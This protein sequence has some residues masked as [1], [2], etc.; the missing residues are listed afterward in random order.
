MRLTAPALR[1]PLLFRYRASEILHFLCATCLFLS[2]LRCCFHCCS[3]FDAILRSDDSH[4]FGTLDI[5]IT[6]CHFEH[7]HAASATP[8][9]LSLPRATWLRHFTLQY[10][11]F[12]D[13]ST[14]AF[15][16]RAIYLI[17]LRRHLPAKCHGDMRFL[18]FDYD[19]V[20]SLPLREVFATRSAA[21]I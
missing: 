21:T 19:G 13:A 20:S 8:P 18:S 6:Q 5:D 1:S 2:P 4:A 10:H 7:Y 3:P 15:L 14:Y 12:R 11:Y 17:T 9:V 16:M